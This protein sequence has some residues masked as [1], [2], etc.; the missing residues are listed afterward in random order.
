[1]INHRLL[2]S[3]QLGGVRPR[4]GDRSNRARTTHEYHRHVTPSVGERRHA[5][6][7]RSRS[8]STLDTPLPVRRPAAMH[9]QNGTRG[10]TADLRA[11]AL[12]DA[13]SY[14]PG[15]DGVP[16]PA[17]S[18]S[19]TASSQATTSPLRSRTI[20]A[21][22]ASGGRR[23]RPRLVR[24][25]DNKWSGRRPRGRATSPRPGRID[26]QHHRWHWNARP[27]H[28]RSYRADRPQTG[29][30]LFDALVALLIA[31]VVLSGLSILVSEIADPR[32]LVALTGSNDPSNAATSP[33]LGGLLAFIT[34]SRL[35]S[36]RPWNVLT[37]VVMGSLV[38]VAILSASIAV[39]GLA[40][41]LMLGWAIGLAVRYILGI[42][43]T[44]PSGAE[45][46]DAL[47]R[48]GLPIT[49]LRAQESTSRRSPL[50]GH[51][52]VRPITRRNR[53]RPGPRRRRAPSRNLDV[54][55]PTRGA[56]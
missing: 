33:I 9:P 32:L 15:S 29:R 47:D 12:A 38:I 42:Q 35:I 34:A 26:H 25:R 3:I 39:A 1:M 27:P 21:R 5:D 52:A 8:E 55:S 16:S 24:H 44:R 4:R 2:A 7:R 30:Q 36:R 22:P 48:G 6:G 41:S 50:P 31:V 11:D 43:T 56:P 13:G 49:M 37:L 40:A 14:V 23:R 17:P 10:E 45:V 19:R 18:S 53:S 51:G 20:R 46:A 54:A 28:R